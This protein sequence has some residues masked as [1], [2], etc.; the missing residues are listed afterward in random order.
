MEDKNDICIVGV[1][2][3]AILDLYSLGKGPEQTLAG[4]NFRVILTGHKFGTE[5]RQRL[6]RIHFKRLLH[7]WR[8]QVP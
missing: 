5:T 8:K 2:T 1:Y 4:G 7:L 6:R 3:I